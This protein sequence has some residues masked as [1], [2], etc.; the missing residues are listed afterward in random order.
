RSEFRAQYETLL[1]SSQVRENEL[2]LTKDRLARAD[3]L[4]ETVRRQELVIEK[5]EAMINT[6]MK[7][8]RLKGSG[9][10]TD[11]DRSFLSEHAQVGIETQQLQR[12]VPKSNYATSAQDELAKQ[13]VMYEQQLANLRARDL[14]NQINS[15]DQP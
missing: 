9:A 10:F 4:E 6:Y 3:G 1:K 13:N 15:L 5:L 2:Q 7:E 14:L 8:K 12:R 11:V